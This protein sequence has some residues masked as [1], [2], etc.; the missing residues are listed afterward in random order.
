MGS[1]FHGS[2]GFRIMG[3]KNHFKLP[4]RELKLVVG[5]NLVQTKLSCGTDVH[6]PLRMNN[7]LT[8][9]RHVTS[10]IALGLL[11]SNIQNA[12]P[13]NRTIHTVEMYP[14]H[15]GTIIVSEYV[16][17]SKHPMPAQCL[18]AASMAI[19][20]WS[21]FNE[22]YLIDFSCFLTLFLRDTSSLFTC[23]V[24][25]QLPNLL[26][27]AFIVLYTLLLHYCMKHY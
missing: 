2:S 4:K 15:A 27:Y 18:G 22:V 14:S 1:R 9:A 26:C 19:D 16:G 7:C 24:I 25:I 23:L 21:Y 12:K 20:S 6:V 8:N 10:P 3:R 17:S 11:I 13:P 5:H